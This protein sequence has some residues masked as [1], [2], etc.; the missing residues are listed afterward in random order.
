ML[1]KGWGSGAAMSMQ[2][3]NVVKHGLECN[4][5][6]VVSIDLLQKAFKADA[7][8]YQWPSS[9]RQEMHDFAREIVDGITCSESNVCIIALGKEV[10]DSLEAA[11]RDLDL[12]T[13]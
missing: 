10:C 6:K 9:V 2:V 12:K 8:D 4:G 5:R 7:L 3:I 1:E 11:K 13:R